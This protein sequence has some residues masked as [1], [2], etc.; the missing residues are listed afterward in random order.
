MLDAFI[1]LLNVAA[2]LGYG[3]IPLDVFFPKRSMFTT[4]LPPGE[5]PKTPDVPIDPE[6]MFLGTRQLRAAGDPRDSSRSKT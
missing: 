4:L 6:G 3:A 2:F 1:I 5:S